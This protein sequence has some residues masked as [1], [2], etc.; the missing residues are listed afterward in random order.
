MNP[1]AACPV[2]PAHDKEMAREFLAAL[3]P[4]ADRFTFQLF[5]DGAHKHAE[6]FHGTIDEVWSKVEALNRPQEQ[7]GVFVTINATDFKG[8]RNNNIVHPRALFADADGSEQ[9]QRSMAAINMCGAPPSMVVTTGRGLHLYYLCRDIPLDQFCALQET[10]IDKLGTDPAV[11]DLPR[12]MRLPGTLHLKNPNRPLLVKL[13]KGLVRQ[14]TVSALL[15]KLEA[16]P[17]QQQSKNNVVVPFK[18][19]AGMKPSAKFAA[20]PLESLADGIKVSID[21][22]QSAVLALPPL[23]IATEPE[24]MKLAR[25]LAHEAT[26]YPYQSEQ[27]WAILDGASRGAPGYDEVG[28][29]NRWERY[30]QEA[31][32]SGDHITIKTVLH[33]ARQHGWKG[34]SPPIVPV[35]SPPVAWSAAALQVRFS[36]IPHRR[37]LYGTY[38]IRGEVIV[39]SAPGGAGKTALATGMAVE[40]ATGKEL[41]GEKIYRAHDL[42]T[43]F[44]NAEDSGTEIKRR[45]WAFCIEHRIAE[46]ELG[47]LSVVGVDDPLVQRLSFLRTV[48][49]KVSVLDQDAFKVLEA[50]VEELH[51]DLIILDPLVAFCAGGNMNDNAVMSLVMRELKRVATKFSCAVLVVHHTRKG[52]DTGSAEAVSGAAAIVNL[53]RRAIMPVPMTEEEAKKFAVL[54]SERF[55]YFKVVDAKSNL[56]PR[57]ADSPWYKLHSIELPNPEPPV[58]PFGDNVQAVT[59]ESLSSLITS[60]AASTAEDQKIRR[61]IIDTVDRGKI[62]NGASYPYSP[63]LAGAKNQRALLEDAMAAVRTATVPQQWQLCD[64]EAVVKR[65]IEAMRTDGWLL[66]ETIGTGRFHRG[67]ALRVDRPRTPWPDAI[68]D[69][70]TTSADAPAIAREDLQ[71]SAEQEGG[72]LVNSPAID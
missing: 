47:R 14:W 18:I 48:D 16:L 24:W 44:I 12:V 54:P 2:T 1:Q 65:T 27:F 40:I 43:L 60:S 59:R 33:L 64:L 3:D 36:N 50:A 51:P 8:R 66:Q 53:A 57:S 13:H 31:L 6:I 15:A 72:Q 71:A 9:V 29:L 56:A 21:E 11:K 37:W 10:L 52:G 23:A 26:V 70:G 55:R 30:K 67:Q 68:P 62:I 19:P 49:Q 45:I 4:V 34:W 20:I 38:L 32:T 69:R 5:G 7:M 22:I 42:R 25:G 35:P 46:Q 63:S 17:T 39:V 28:N 61:A 58:Y 41:L